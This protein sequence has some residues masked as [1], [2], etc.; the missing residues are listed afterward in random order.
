MKFF[1]WIDKLNKLW[2]NSSSPQKSTG[3]N[4][5]YKKNSL[6]VSN[7]S[8]YKDRNFTIKK[9]LPLKASPDSP[10]SPKNFFKNFDSPEFK[11]FFQKFWLLNIFQFFLKKCLG[12]SKFMKKISRFSQFFKKIWLSQIF[13]QKF[14]LI[15][16]FVLKKFSG[17]SKFLKKISGEAFSK[18]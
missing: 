9:R 16:S 1:L 2:E 13:F 11:I 6:T 14:W 18:N 8:R 3:P 12:E 15:F 5:F 7:F 17:E 10:D 4:Y